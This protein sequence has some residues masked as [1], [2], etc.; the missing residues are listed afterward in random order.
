MH[1][2]MENKITNELF[3]VCYVLYRT[4]PQFLFR[5]GYC[6]TMPCCS[7]GDGSLVRRVTSSKGLGLGFGLKL[8]LWLVLECL[9]KFNDTPKSRIST[10]FIHGVLV[11]P[12]RY[13]TTSAT[14]TVGPVTL[15]IGDPS[16]Q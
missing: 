6:F 12:F 8:G 11:L 7:A 3:R 1:L 9:R 15:Q 16:D 2:W 10:L 4:R 14:T 5:V 13:G